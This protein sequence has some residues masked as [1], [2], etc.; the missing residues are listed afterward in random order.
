MHDLITIQFLTDWHLIGISLAITGI[1]I[2]LLSVGKI[3]PILRDHVSLE[4]DAE[5]PQAINVNL[6]IMCY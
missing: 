4:W 2:I 1:N 3:I 6:A 5:N